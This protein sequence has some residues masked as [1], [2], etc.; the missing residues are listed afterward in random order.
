MGDLEEQTITYTSPNGDLRWKRDSHER[1]F[2]QQRIKE[3]EQ[4]L[5]LLRSRLMT[6]SMPNNM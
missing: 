6:N 4:E 1:I 3:L 2:V 5:K